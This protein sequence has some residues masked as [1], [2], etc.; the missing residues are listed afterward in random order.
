ML[1]RILA[2]VARNPNHV[3][4]LVLKMFI[5]IGRL[6]YTKILKLLSCKSSPSHALITPE[7]KISCVITFADSRRVRF[8]KQ[9]IR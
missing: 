6:S 3:N 1:Y 5:C 7:I 8:L 9:A 4:T 2:I